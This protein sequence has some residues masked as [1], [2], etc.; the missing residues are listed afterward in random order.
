MPPTRTTPFTSTSTSTSTTPPTTATAT[1][2][3][4]RPPWSTTTAWS[5]L[6]ATHHL[7]PW[8]HRT[9]RYH[10]ALSKKLYLRFGL[11]NAG[12]ASGFWREWAAGCIVAQCDEGVFMFS[13]DFGYACLVAVG[14]GKAVGI[15]R[16]A[17]DEQMEG[18]WRR[19]GGVYDAGAEGQWP[20]DGGDGEEEEGGK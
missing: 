6:H 7:T 3:S 12:L 9:T 4:T 1:R 10:T 18:A 8:G 14:F 20:G 19:M 16:G 5:T 15:I 17:R 13:H 11:H 2:A